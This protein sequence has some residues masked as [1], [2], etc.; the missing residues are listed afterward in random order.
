MIERRGFLLTLLW[1]ILLLSPLP[2]LA[3]AMVRSTAMKAPTIA[4]IFIE[5]NAVRVELEIGVADLAAFQNL[6]PDELL[7][8]MGQDPAP[9]AE[10]LPRFFA[11][12]LTIRPLDGEPLPGT[13]IAMEGRRRIERDIITGESLPATGDEEAVVHA[14]LL[15]P[16]AGQPQVLTIKP[17]TDEDGRVE[18]SMGFVT[19]HRGLPIN[20]F[21]YLSTAEAVDLDWDDPWYSK[22]RNRNLWRAYNAPI[23]AFLYAEPYEMRVEVIL[24][25]R[26]LQAWVDLGLL[27]D[28]MLHVGDQAAVKQAAAAFLATNMVLTVDG[29]TVTPQVDRINYLRR[30]LRASTVIDPPEDLDLNSATL[31]LIFVHPTAGLPQTAALTWNLFAAKHPIVRAAATDEAGPLP[32]RLMPDD[33]VLTWQNFLKNPTLPTLVDISVPAAGKPL[34]LPLL[35]GAILLVASWFLTQAIMRPERRRQP[36]I[37]GAVLLVVGVVLWP[38][39]S[40]RVDLGLRPPRLT[41][42]DTRTVV[43][44]LLRNV[45]VAFDFRGEDQIYDT[46]SRSTS[47]DLLTQV[48]LDT[49]KSLELQSQGGARV[50]VKEVELL[51]IESVAAEGGGRFTATCTWTV[52]GSVGHWGHIHQRINQYKARIT[53][54]PVDGE[55]KITDL[56]VLQEERVS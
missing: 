38:T 22:F 51:D 55:W 49:R 3:D 28:E 8:K 2:A 44:S 13:V 1:T 50:K 53:V 41:E 47:G 40:I 56:Q 4:E 48:Y 17:P 11:E 36:L 5:T 37:R 14:V 23:N 6:L 27:T 15:Y 19:Y 35:G 26:D 43:T 34:R 25:P 29:Q 32:Y 33:N 10:R 39:V 54:Q 9:L 52:R 18:T 24:R 21:R 45:Y 30:T 7:R 12:D 20:D 42:D 31:G 46:L 16:M